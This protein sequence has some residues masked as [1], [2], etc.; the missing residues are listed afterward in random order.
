M[1]G[2]AE[3]VEEEPGGEEADEDEERDRVGY[4]GE[5]ED[6]SDGCEVIDA[7]I[8]VVFAD[9]ECGIGEGFGFCESGAVNEFGPRATLRESVAERF[10]EVVYEGA[11][12]WGGDWGLG[13]GGCGCGCCDGGGV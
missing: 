6:E 12:G 11:E 3:E 10:G 5:S 7:E 4:E 9:S 8:G 2:G 13:L 1:V